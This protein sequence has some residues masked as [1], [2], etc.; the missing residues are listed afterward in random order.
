VRW[1]QNPFSPETLIWRPEAQV[2]LCIC[3]TQSKSPKDL[4]V[5]GK[6][7]ANYKKNFSL[8]LLLFP[9]GEAT[10]HSTSEISS[11]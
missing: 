4:P 3:E 7:S 1:S 2:A 11:E 6:T 9:A 10:E 5:S 8:A